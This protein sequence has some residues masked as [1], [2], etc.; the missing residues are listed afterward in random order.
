VTG[1]LD[2]RCSPLANELAG[3]WAGRAA[4]N[5][6]SDRFPDDDISDLRNSGLLGLLV[7]ERLGG[8][9]GTFADYVSVAMCLGAGSGS[10]A[11]LFNMHACVTGALAG[12]PDDVARALGVPD[13]F[14]TARDEVLRRAVA[15]AMY[16][17]AISER[18][19]GSRLSAIR[20]TYA[21]EAGGFRVRGHK[22]TCSG[23]GHLDGYLIAARDLDASEGSAPRISYFILPADAIGAVE[24]TW[25]P[26][27][28]RSTCSNGFTIDSIVETNAL[29][30]IEGIALLL[31]ETM[32]EW[33]VASYAAVYVGVARAAFDAAVAYAQSTMVTPPIQDAEV[34]DVPL[35]SSPWVR[36]RIGR[37]EAQVAAARL[38][39]EDAAR[40]VV[41]ES[42]TPETLRAVYR[43]KLVAGDTAFAVAA[44]LTEAC[45]LGALSRGGSLE[46]ILRDARSGAVIPPSSD[47]SANVLGAFA[48][49][50]DP[51]VGFGMRP[52]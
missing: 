23:A 4:A 46:R 37:A 17:V 42:G 32:P 44:S 24:Q 8:M 49:G 38:V 6:R 43:A 50:V 39:V 28:M 20:T 47:I 33:L 48:L 13:S 21:Q 52:W 45:G 30:G 18:K 15:G 11:L 34:R 40:R 9:G 12:V 22:S 27:G 16:G 10:S 41:E 26:M 25:D 35:S 29:I 2:S 5:D 19:S 3:S 1:P 31:A 7:P 14:F 36:Q 51:G